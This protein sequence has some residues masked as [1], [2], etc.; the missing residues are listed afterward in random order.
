MKSN[1]NILFDTLL[2]TKLFIILLIDIILLN[3]SYK[4]AEGDS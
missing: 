1:K 4:I 2:F 3:C